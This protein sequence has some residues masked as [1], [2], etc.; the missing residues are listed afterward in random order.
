MATSNG[1]V[2]Y[3]VRTMTVYS[4]ASLA[5]YAQ[6]VFSQGVPGRLALVTCEDWNGH[7]YNSNVVVL[8]DPLPG[9]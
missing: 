1:V 2:D 9:R 6:R 7:T 3:R 8:A 4:K 5:T